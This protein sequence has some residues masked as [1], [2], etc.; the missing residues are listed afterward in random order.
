MHSVEQNNPVTHLRGSVELQLGTIRMT[1]DEADMNAS[2]DE[3]DLRGNVHLS[4][5]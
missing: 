1:A 2:T 4:T 5:K 3:V